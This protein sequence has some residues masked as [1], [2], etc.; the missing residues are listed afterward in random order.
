MGNEN[1][2]KKLL[3]DSPAGYAYHKIHCDQD[4]VPC[5]YEFLEVNEA[6]EKIT[7][8]D[9]EAIL[10]KK[11]TEAIPNIKEDEFDWISFYGEI[12]LGGGEKEFV[13]YANALN[14]WYKVKALCPEKLYFITW[15]M[16][17]SEEKNAIE[18]LQKAKAEN[19]SI[20]EGANLGTFQWNAQTGEQIINERWAEMI[21]Y[22]IEELFPMNIK[23][24]ENFCHPDDFRRLKVVMD[25]SFQGKVDRYNFEF[26]MKHKDGRWIWVKSLSKINSWTSE[27][28]P[29]LVS[30][31]HENITARKELKI[32]LEESER[33][34]RWIF[35]QAPIGIVN[36]SMDG[37][38]IRANQTF[39][40]MIGYSI[41]E[42]LALNFLDIT[43][44]EDQ[45][46]SSTGASK[47][48]DGT[49]QK[50]ETRKRYQKKD[51]NIIWGD[52]SASMM[53]DQEGKPL[54]F[55]TFV[56]DVTETR[57]AQEKLNYLIYHNHMT[58]LYNRRFYEEELKRIDTERNL[59]VALIMADING[60]KLA[61]DAFGH[62]TGDLILVKAAEILKSECR[63]DEIIA[64]IGGDEFIILL[65]KTSKEEAIKLI[66]RI[67]TSFEGK[68]IEGLPLSISL[69]YAV[70]TIKEERMDEIFKN[71]EDDM[72]RHKLS[73]TSS[74]RSQTIKM[75]MNSLYEK[76]NREM[77]HSNRV[78][79]LCATIATHMYFSKDDVAQMR[80]VGLMHDIGKIGISDEILNKTSKLDEEEWN[81]IKKHSE[82]GYRILNTSNEFSEIAVF[83]LEHQEKWDGTGYPNGLKGKE[84]SKEARIIAITD[85]YDAMTS[86]RAYRK[87]MDHQHAVEEIK[88][89]AGTQ[90]DPEIVKVF[91]EK[92]L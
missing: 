7:G 33:S 64:R 49:S 54:Y 67:K 24:W 78:G 12:A 53:R 70:K 55:N 77:L 59:P 9:R 56:K 30:G 58:G 92:V 87:G 11:I 86:D 27:G 73:E 84:I 10:G 6:F 32:K 72:Y 38:F 42:L 25:K 16:D 8:L 26:R 35:E 65:P 74:M 48:I 15:F 50:F 82:I 37:R 13:Q 61:N 62:K 18:E 51:G 29:L 34:Y 75:I 81:E 69:G 36:T 39:C 68:T 19:L 40:K 91:L 2:Y 22:T 66:E 14:K 41:E 23:K 85:A 20:I 4:G 46:I 57:K 17:I 88:R 45:N 31:I 28:K 60:L 47:M 71:A 5:D 3:N 76:N 89:C 83:V 63:A 80:L 21:G 44:P 52:L 79:E 90:F 43:P 1:F